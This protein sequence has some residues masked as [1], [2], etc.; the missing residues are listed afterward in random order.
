M[1]SIR[2]GWRWPRTHAGCIAVQDAT[3]R[4]KRLAD[5]K[6]AA[7]DSRLRTMSQ[8][9]QRGLPRPNHKK[10][11]VHGSAPK[12]ATPMEVAAAMVEAEIAAIVQ[13]EAAAYPAKGG[14]PKKKDKLPPRVEL[15][16]EAMESAALLVLEEVQEE[17]RGVDREVYE[18]VWSEVVDDVLFLP[19]SQRSPWYTH[20]PPRKIHPVDV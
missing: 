6:Q 19:V 15:S 17:T 16:R 18:R 1:R 10:L 5:E 2:T 9:L 13:Y 7:A 12:G 20:T 11:V 4:K 14:K 3:D 8:P